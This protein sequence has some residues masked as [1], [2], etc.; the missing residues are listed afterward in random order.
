MRGKNRTVI[1]M[2]RGALCI[3]LVCAAIPAAFAVP[4][5]GEMLSISQPDGT[6][7]QLYLRGDEFYHWYE[8]PEGN[9]V[10][11]DAAG[12]WV[13]GVSDGAGDV[14]PGTQRVSATRAEAAGLAPVRPDPSVVEQKVLQGKKAL[15]Y[16]GLGAMQAV[17]EATPGDPMN[18]PPK[19]IE[20]NGTVKNLVILVVFSDH[21]TGTD[22]LAAS[23]YDPLFNQTGYNTDGAAG[24]VKDYYNEVSYGNLTLQSTIAAGKW[25]QLP[26]TEAYYDANINDMITSAVQLA[27]AA[28]V[29]FTQFDTDNDGWIDAIDIIHSGYGEEAGA[30]ATSIWS[31]RGWVGDAAAVQADGV[32]VSG[33]HTEPALRGTAGTNII[34][35]GVICH[36]TGHFFGLPDLYDT[37]GIG[38]GGACEGI[39]AWGLMGSGSWGALGGGGAQRPTHMCT[40]SKV[41][42]G[43]V[44]P[45]PLHTVNNQAISQIETNPVAFTISEGLP[46]AE[47]FMVSNRQA[48]GFDASLQDGGGLEILHVDDANPN[49]NTP[50]DLKITFEEA[51]G[52]WSL[53]GSTRSQSGDPWNNT[54]ATTFDGNTATSPTTHSN[55]SLG[56]SPSSIAFSGISANGNPMFFT[57]QTLVPSMTSPVNDNDGNFNVTWT[58]PA[59]SPT[60]YQLDQATTTTV[61]TYTDNANSEQQFR[62]DWIVLG[63]ARRVT[64]PS[65][66]DTV[67]LMQ[68]YDST[69]AQWLDLFNAMKLRKVFRVTGST[70]ISYDVRYVMAAGTPSKDNEV[71]YF[72]I[73][74]VGD[75]A[76]TTLSKF[77]GVSIGSWTS[78]TETSGELAAFVGYDC[79]VRFL[80]VN[81]GGST[82][83]WG[84][85]WPDNGIAIED[86]SI[87]N[88]QIT[89]YAWSTLSS[90]ATTPY[91][92]SGS[93]GGAHFY[94]VRAFSGGSWQD[95]SNVSRTNVNLPPPVDLGAIVLSDDDGLNSPSLGYTNALD[96]DVSLQGVVGTPNQMMLSESATFAGGVWIPF[97]NPTS[98]TIQSPTEGVKT[99]YVQL[100]DGFTTAGSTGD[101]SDTITLDT[102]QPGVSSSASTPNPSNPWVDVTYDEAVDFGV[103]DAANYAASG[104]GGPIG[105]NTVTY[106]SG[107]TYRLVTDAQVLGDSYSVTIS[108]VADLAGNLIDPANNTAMWTGVPV[109]VSKFELH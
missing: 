81:N 31:H 66:G 92:I 104:T 13:Y 105:V 16:Y 74:K 70:T 98:Y 67:Y 88:A 69:A 19:R 64:P 82:W 93:T 101:K 62:E 59:G 3:A 1:W 58:T 32:W 5:T 63:T 44:T 39:G 45:T 61:T 17:G 22:T 9:I 80:V 57:L 40:W 107:T 30:P 41:K 52:N 43:W 108:N 87:N 95:W 56:G 102:T 47:S 89:D 24:S 78:T 53:M 11:Q 75:T 106:Q 37:D 26:N 10:M 48:T 79:E 42:M 77:S 68:F 97:Q 71:A 33:Y 76:W 8:T 21:T 51:D 25:L 29:D 72:Q 7:T 49:N 35:I 60:Q 27:D 12:W 103:L 86:F 36:E 100:G 54:N 6:V 55:P 2:V 109:T 14:R 65:E 99:V 85:G 23:A 83:T 34:R 73:R 20:P 90:T 18:K 38:S 96:V 50:Y 4:A 84:P 28:G 91:A 15:G 46:S 94:R